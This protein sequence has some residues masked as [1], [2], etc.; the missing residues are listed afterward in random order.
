MGDSYFRAGVGIAVVRDDGRVL[1]LERRE[2]PGSWQLPQGGIEEGEHA[3]AAAWRE[4]KEETGLTEQH[5][6]LL[7]RHPAWLGYELAPEARDD[8]LRRGQVHR[9][10]VMVLTDA[11]AQIDLS[12]VDKDKSQP[13]FKDHRWTTFDKLLRDTAEFRVPA[14]RELAEFASSCLAPAAM[15]GGRWR[16]WLRRPSRTAVERLN[17]A[18]A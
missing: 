18:L 9:W 11:T 14:Y 15:P 8:R 10:Y 4:L 12:T 7:G 2:R 17:S 5:V 13:E 3:D 6:R 16:R 1:A